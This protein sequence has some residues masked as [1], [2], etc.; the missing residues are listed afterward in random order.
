MAQS[1]CQAAAVT[2]HSGFGLVYTVGRGCE[3]PKGVGGPT[4]KHNCHDICKSHNLPRNQPHLTNR[5]TCIAAFHVYR[6]NP[7][8][9][10]AGD[11]GS[12]TLGLASAEVK[13]NYSSKGCGP[14]FCCC[15][16]PF[17]HQ[18]PLDPIGK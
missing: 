10:P 8:T 14:N 17:N 13:C 4:A 1:M 9:N 12:A 7:A 11:V 3:H 5:Y 6:N 15:F 16:L 2:Y 18:Q